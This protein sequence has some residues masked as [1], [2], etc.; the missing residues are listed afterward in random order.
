[1]FKS[2]VCFLKQL[3]LDGIKMLFSLSPGEEKP[4]KMGQVLY[5]CWYRDCHLGKKSNLSSPP[6]SVF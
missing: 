2:F 6:A 4:E 3:F 5:C 1:M